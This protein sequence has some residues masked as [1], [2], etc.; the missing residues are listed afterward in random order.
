MRTNIANKNQIAVSANN[1][2]SAI[3]TEQTLDT[4]MLVDIGDVINSEPRREDN[5]NELTGNE[6]ATDIYDNGG[7]SGFTMNLNKA[8][9]QHFAFLLGFGLGSVSTS[10]AGTGYAHTITPIADDLDLYRSNP[11]FTAGMKLGTIA[12]RRYASMG[13][14]SVS[15]TFSED[16]WV[17]ISGTIKGTGKV[18]SNIVEEE[19]TALNTAI[20]L[21]LAANGVQGATAAARLDSIH[22]IRVE[23]DSGEWTEVSFSAVSSATPAVITITAPGSGGTS[24]TYKVLYVPTEPAWCTFPARIS[25]TPMRVSQM[26]CNIGGAWD[27]SAFV[28]GHTISAFIKTL[29]YS[30]QNS[31]QV[32]F[33]PGAGGAYASRMLR[34]AR[35]QTLKINKEMRDYILQN[36]IDTNETFGIKVLCEGMEFD[37]GHKYGVTMIFPKCGVVSAPISVDGKRIAEAGDLRVLQHDTYG[38]VIAIVKNLVATYAA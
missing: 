12:K 38:S 23:L 26:S 10:A 1:K 8:Q 11:T 32:K 31:L 37:T 16:N 13:V 25:E 5:S 28:G 20:S 30:L 33:S 7:L 19:I 6:E 29:E 35:V 15:A 21:T 2:E 4:S 22:A 17:K 24:V 14:D 34:D 18:T 27:G 3:N 9:P 36:Y